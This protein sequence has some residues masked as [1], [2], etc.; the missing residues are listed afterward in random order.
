MYCPFFLLIIERTEPFEKVFRPCFDRNFRHFSL[1]ILCFLSIL[2]LPV[3]H[4][5]SLFLTFMHKGIINR[6]VQNVTGKGLFYEKN[7]N[8]RGR[9]CRTCHTKYRIDAS[10]AKLRFWN[11]LYRFLWRNWKTA[12]RGTGCS[13]LW[14]FFW[15][16]KTLLWS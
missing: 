16:I 1:S 7:R 5:I 4:F 2:S 3:F 6:E 12:D 8:D 10:L 11:F 15:K 9:H 14:H 13:L